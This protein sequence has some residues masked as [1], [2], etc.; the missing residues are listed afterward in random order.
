MNSSMN[1]LKKTV[2]LALLFLT[3]FIKSSAQDTIRY[4]DYKWEAC[5]AD[6]ARYLSLTTKTDSGYYKRD[7]YIREKKVQMLGT[8]SDSLCKVANGYF[9]FYH[10]NG[11]P[12]AFGRYRQNKKDGLWM[13]FH[14]NGFMSDSTTYSNGKII[15]TNL[16]WHP[17]GYLRDSI[18]LQKDRS[19]L[20]ISWFDNGVPAAAGRF[21][22]GM[23][24]SGKWKFYHR[25]G[26]ISSIEIYKESK[27]V[28]KQYFNESGEL[29]KDTT[30]TDRRAEFKG[31]IEAWLKYIARQI[32][33]PSGYKIINADMAIVVVTF[34]INENGE[35][36]NVFTSSS[37]HEKFD[38]IAERAIKRSPKWAPAMSH[39]RKIKQNFNQAVRFQ[40]YK[41]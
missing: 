37:F 7:Y 28:D 29:M 40:N 25:N 20:V 11:M 5:K 24:Q 30:N 12:Q 15:G 36:E 17:N 31:G 33:F 21:S 14:N 16:T 8:Y 6:V 10:S 32:Y 26:N 23:K 18:S 2:Y 13:G 1:L 9:T 38:Q 34:T 19:G 27:L 41:D 3:I 4:Y 22:E 35:I 39:N